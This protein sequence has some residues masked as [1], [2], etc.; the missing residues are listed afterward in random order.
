MPK[1]FSLI[2]HDIALTIQWFSDALI[3]PRIAKTDTIAFLK[4]LNQSSIIIREMFLYDPENALKNLIGGFLLHVSLHPIEFTSQM[5]LLL[6]STS[7]IFEIIGW[8]LKSSFI[9]MGLAGTGTAMAIENALLGF[10]AFFD[11]LQSPDDLLDFITP[12]LQLNNATL[13]R[14]NTYNISHQESLRSKMFGV[15]KHFNNMTEIE[16]DEAFVNFRSCVCNSTN[17]T[18]IAVPVNLQHVKFNATLVEATF[19]CHRDEQGHA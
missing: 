19:H 5:L 17:D 16:R 8:G 2:L 14:N 11:F 3:D 10:L 4:E 1:I 9:Y 12:S 13:N 7:F 6:I 18:S 15:H